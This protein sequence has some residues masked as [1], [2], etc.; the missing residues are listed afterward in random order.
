MF[1]KHF[2][3]GL[4]HQRVGRWG[5]VRESSQLSARI[6]AI[7]LRAVK[8]KDGQIASQLTN[9]LAAVSIWMN[10]LKRWIKSLADW[11]NVNTK[12]KRKALPDDGSQIILIRDVIVEKDGCRTTWFWRTRL[13]SIEIR[14]YFVEKIKLCSVQSRKRFVNS[15]YSKYDYSFRSN[16]LRRIEEHGGNIS[17]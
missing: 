11:E 3:R 15:C 14:L 17:W 9:L 7:L 4:D 12:N 10:T 5:Y 16:I 8:Q 1:S 6:S 2:S 13:W